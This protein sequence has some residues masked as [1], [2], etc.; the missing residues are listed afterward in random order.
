MS[1]KLV[2][3][4]LVTILIGSAVPLVAAQDQKVTLDLWFNS[5]AAF[6]QYNEAVI[7]AFEEQHPNIDIVYHPYANEPFKTALQVAI[8]SDDPPDIFFNW[9]GDDTFR[10]AREG[11]LLDLTPYAEEMGWY[12][13]ISPAALDAFTQ[14]GKLYAGPYS[15]EV[16]YYYYNLDIFKDQ[17]IE[18]PQTFDEL[19]NVCRTLRD[20]GITPMAFGNQERWEGV[21]Y[22]TIFNQ[23]MA[24]EDT[25]LRD[26]S[27]E[28][29]KDELFTDPGYVAAFQ[30]LLDLQDAGCFQDAL[31][32]TTPDAAAALFYLGQTAMYYQGTWLIGTLTQNDFEGQYGMFRMP[33]IT[34]PEA[35]GNQNYVL[36]GPIGLEVS[37]KTE[38]P[39]AAVAFIDFYVSQQAQK[40]LVD[41]TGRIPSRSDAVDPES[42]PWQM[43]FVVN[44]LAEAEGA[45]SWLDVVLENRVSEVYLNAIQEVLAGTMTPEEAVAAVREEALIVKADLG[46]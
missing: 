14:D 12:D 6:D 15:Q 8:A 13:A 11:H 46:K 45:V 31:N 40:M 44:D 33:P 41:M 16:K 42:A 43:Q 22:L 29:A 27:L 2:A 10:L 7:A 25:I 37:S 28:A 38:N 3:L 35:K 5:D 32:S 1:R 36:M 18:V 21:H 24:G 23:K 9:A 26:Y 34:D 30:R 20:A 19:L 39:D 17:G 4:L